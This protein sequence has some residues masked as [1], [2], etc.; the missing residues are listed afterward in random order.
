MD[1]SD[2][3]RSIRSNP[4]HPIE[5]RSSDWTRSIR[6]NPIDRNAWWAQLVAGLLGVEAGQDAVIRE[7]LYAAK[8]ATVEGYAHTVAEFTAKISELWDR[9]AG[10][11]LGPRPLQTGVLSADGFSLSFGRTAIPILRVVYGSG[12]ESV[13][14][15]FFPHGARGIIAQ[16][17]LQS[18][19]RPS[20]PLQKH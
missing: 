17:A 16:A 10:S 11:C 13:P 15:A 6:S 19:G 4:V 7:Y 14:G 8:D 12:V 20:P 9:L 5:P 1:R 3:T 18:L 2:R